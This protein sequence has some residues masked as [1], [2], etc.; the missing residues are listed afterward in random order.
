[1]AK[2][3]KETKPVPRP[4]AELKPRRFSGERVIQ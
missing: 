2:E 4:H 3:I 1:M